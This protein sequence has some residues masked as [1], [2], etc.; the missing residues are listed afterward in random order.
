MAQS[1]RM[2]QVGRWRVRTVATARKED[3][4]DKGMDGKAGRAAARPAKAGYPAAIAAL[5]ATLCL[6]WQDA[7]AQVC[8]EPL[9][10]DF[11]KTELVPTGKMNFP[12]EIAVIPDGRV[13]IAEMKSGRIML[14]KPG[15]NTPTVAGTIATRFDNEDGMLG[16]AT[17]PDFAVSKFLYAFY[18]EPGPSN[19]AH[20]LSRFTVNGDALDMGA[21]VEILRVP[22]VPT[23]KWHA[24]GGLVFDDKGNLFIT[25]G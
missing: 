17:P 15:S 11:S 13:F 7:R 2:A 23:G 1:D 12:V 24:A 21:K 8:A 16:I 5:A 14:Y 3:T 20:V 10:S 6:G 19:P 22:R 4:M 18:T 25:T 9:A